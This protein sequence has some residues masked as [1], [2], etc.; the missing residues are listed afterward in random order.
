MK[1]FLQDA[2]H[3]LSQ[4][5]WLTK[6]QAV[7]ISIITVAFVLVSAVVFWAVDLVLTELYKL[8]Q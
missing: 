3:E 6:N 7:R 5:T 2:L 4:V 1:A 8:I